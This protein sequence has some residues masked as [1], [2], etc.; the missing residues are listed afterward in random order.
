MF[1]KTL[2]VLVRFIFG[3]P[4]E[5]LWKTSHRLWISKVIYQKALLIIIY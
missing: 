4:V 5:N 3:W 1:Y 2:Y